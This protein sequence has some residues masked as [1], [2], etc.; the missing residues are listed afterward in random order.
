MSVKVTVPNTSSD[1]VVFGSANT[2]TAA[3]VVGIDS[4][5]S[6]GQLAFKTTASGTST[7]RMRIDAS[8]NVG[9][10]TSSLSNTPKLNV[11]GSI[12]ATDATI[13][14]Y[15]YDQAGIDF[16]A[17][18]KVG[19]IFGTS[20]NTTGGILTF[21]TGA[22]GTN[23]E[24]MRIDSSGKVLIASASNWNNSIFEVNYGATGN[25]VVAFANSA[26]TSPYGIIMK[27]TGATPN[28]TS[29]EFLYCNDSTA[30]RMSVRSNG[31]IGNFS[32]NNV[33]LSDA[34]YKTDITPAKSYLDTICAIPVVTFKYK[35]QTDDELNLGVIAQ[36]VDAVAPELVDHSGFGEAPEGEDP[37]LAIY[38]TDLQYALMKCIQELK[39]E[40]D[41]VKS[42]LATLK[43]TV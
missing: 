36:D 33:N 41:T 34:R 6:N 14:S 18:T 16:V 12:I 28:G 22:N 2:P 17:S 39:A 31:G 29:N 23:A 37:Y 40:L 15:T 24:R 42:E 43:G 19:R 13:G 30:L 38:Q 9:I 20:S 26:A 35:D 21:V 10:G 8:G 32:A 5:S 3:E 7:E 4:G 27:Y 11:A 1:S 25:Q